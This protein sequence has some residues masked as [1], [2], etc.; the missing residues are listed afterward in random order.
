MSF[1][2][3]F[4]PSC[5]INIDVHDGGGEAEHEDADSHH[6]VPQDDLGVVKDRSRPE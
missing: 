4:A 3:I 2:G 1:K 5:D 6:I